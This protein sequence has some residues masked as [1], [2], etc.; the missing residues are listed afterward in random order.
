MLLNAPVHLDAGTLE[1]QSTHLHA[2]IDDLRQEL[3]AERKRAVAAEMRARKA[4]AK[5]AELGETLRAAKLEADVTRAEENRHSGRSAAVPAQDWAR[6]QERLRSSLAT[7]HVSATPSW[8][9]S[10]PALTLAHAHAAVRWRQS[11]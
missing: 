4:G 10:F 1:V 5:T 7:L 11:Y 9:V 6:A 2:E 8:G 3:A